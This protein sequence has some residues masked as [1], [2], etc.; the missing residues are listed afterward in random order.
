MSILSLQSP[1]RK[2]A[3]LLPRRLT[4]R[5]GSIVFWASVV[6][7][8]LG[9]ERG[10]SQAPADNT[11]VDFQGDPLPAG[12]M[13]RLGSARLRHGHH[14]SDVAFS[15]DG[16][17]VASVGSDHTAHLWDAASGKELRKFVTE[18]PGNAF[19]SSRALHCVT[20]SP[21]GTQLA[22]GGNPPESIRDV[23]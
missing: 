5:L 13:V 12:A 6:S 4:R 2:R 19:T 3:A 17:M 15:P 21:D 7:V 10:N 22:C 16:K 14:V 1:R 9:P 8:V 18:N 20:F 11:S 23:P